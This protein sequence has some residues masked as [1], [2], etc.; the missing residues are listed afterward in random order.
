MNMSAVTSVPEEGPDLATLAAN[1]ERILP[2]VEERAPE[3]EAKGSLTDDVVAALRKSG[4]YT[5]LFPREVGGS[6]V[7]LADAMPLIERLSHA[8]ASA[9]WCANVNNMEGATMALYIPD[10]GIERVFARGADVTVA[11]NGVPRGFARK[12]DGGYEIWGNWAF[13]SGICHAEWVHTGG[14]LVDDD[15]QMIF[16]PTGSPRVVLLHHPRDTIRL[17]GEWDVLGLKATGSYDYEVAEGETIFV[18]DDLAYD[19]DNAVPL[20]GGPQGQLGLAGYSAWAHSSWAL[21]V[22]RRM[23]DEL[24]KVARNRRDAFGKT[25]DSASFKYQLALMEARYRAARAY[26]HE[27]WREICAGLEQG[28]SVTQDQMTDAKLVL[29]H[30]HDVVSEVATFAHRSARSASLYNTVMQRCYRDIHSGT[31]H[32]LM[33]D[34]II[35]EC[36]RQILGA[37]DPGAK[38]TVFG[39]DDGGKA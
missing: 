5:M 38:W 36:G 18:P 35:E 7:S 24:A 14:F 1:L 32:I 8:H 21:G 13:G 26:A 19:F 16:G 3:A 28:G 29:R 4:I 15:K 39:V 34:Q 23:L 10:S 22:G 25:V 37:T 31:Q 30:V 6:D 12:V 11:G 27:T 9:G 33:A 17:K 20:R 2:L